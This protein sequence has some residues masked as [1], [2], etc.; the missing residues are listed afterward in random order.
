MFPTSKRKKVSVCF[1]TR[2]FF[3][4]FVLQLVLIVIIIIITSL[5]KKKGETKL[6]KENKTLL[7][8]KLGI[9]MLKLNMTSN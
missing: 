5:W 4:N 8:I 9:Q 3:K 2:I 1:K 7:I 6:K